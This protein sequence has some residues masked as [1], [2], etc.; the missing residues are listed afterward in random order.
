MLAFSPGYAR[1]QR[2][3]AANGALGPITAE[4][5]TIYAEGP[6]VSLSINNLGPNP[7]R[8]YWTTKDYE[9]DDTGTGVDGFIDLPAG[10]GTV[11]LPCSLHDPTTKDENPYRFHARGQG[12]DTEAIIT[13]V[14]RAAG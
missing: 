3:T 13:L 4:G 9:A 8:I 14:H 10:V 5:V 1:T 7:M 6:T 11:D 12:G 2:W